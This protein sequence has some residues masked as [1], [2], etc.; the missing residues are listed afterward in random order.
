[1]APFNAMGTHIMQNFRCD[2]VEI[3]DGVPISLDKPNVFIQL[4]K[5]GSSLRLEEP[6]TQFKADIDFLI[7]LSY[8]RGSLHTIDEV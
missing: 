7:L 6:Q 1:M 2:L 3:K 8:I 4:N 5:D